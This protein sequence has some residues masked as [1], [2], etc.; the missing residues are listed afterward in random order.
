MRTTSKAPDLESLRP[1]DSCVSLG[2]VVRDGVPESFPGADE[3]LATMDRY[4]IAEALVHDH[5]ARLIHPRE[6]GNRRLLEE[7]RGQPRLH[8]CWVIEPPKKPGRD[9]ARALVEEMLAAGVRAVR[10][11]MKALPP[12]PWVWEDLAAELEEHRV[13]SFLDFGEAGTLGAMSDSDVQGVYE[14][15]RA[16]P[17]LPVTL[18]GVFGGL[19]VHPAVV[20]MIRRLANVHLDTA[21]ILEYWREVA[22]DVGPERVLFFTGA[23]FVD[24]GIYVSNV[25]YARGLDEPAKRLVSGD[26]LRALLDGVR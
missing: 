20:P 7:I 4:C 14:I 11:P 1:F 3:L 10:L 8:P 22:R 12:L 15:A 5:H 16:H 26:N 25:Q 21:G 6:H 17:E 18:S 19:G 23:P 2:R 13:P 9:A 24:P